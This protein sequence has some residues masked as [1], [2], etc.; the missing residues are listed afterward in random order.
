MTRRRIL[1]VSSIKKK[2]N[3]LTLAINDTATDA[4]P[5]GD[6]YVLTG[7]NPYGFLW[8]PSARPNR[9][10]LTE[11]GRSLRHTFV[12]GFKER[13]I[14]ETSTG[15]A[16]I[17][18]RIVFAMKGPAFRS[19]FPVGTLYQHDNTNG[20]QRA[21][22]NLLGSGPDAEPSRDALESV[23]FQGVVN[24]DWSDRINASTDP[25]RVTILSDRTRKF[26]SGNENG[27]YFTSAAWQPINKNLIYNED[28]DGDDKTTDVWSTSGRSG[29]GDIY[30]YDMY[31]CVAGLVE[32]TMSV[33]AQCAYYW[34]ER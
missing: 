12:R 29:V 34:H 17:W 32:D 6:P 4:Q 1:N 16:W 28:E 8:C 33:N 30:I 22:W 5:L 9:S 11:H 21:M 10:F 19:V 18:R 14:M 3:A 27:R 26:N 20:V 31:R 23:L 13:L 2:D 24:R 7:D 15:A 25:E